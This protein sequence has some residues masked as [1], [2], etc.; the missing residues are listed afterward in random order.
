MNAKTVV[1][2][3]LLL[4]IRNNLLCQSTAVEN[5]RLWYN[6]P[7]R[8]STADLKN[9]KE[10]DPE[11]IKALPVGNGFLGAM[12]FGD[13]NREIIQLNEKSLWSG[14]PDD[15]NNP[16]AAGSLN[17]IRQLL[18]EK[19][20]KEANE[21]TEKTQV[22]KGVGSGRGSGANSPYGSFQILGNL[23]LDF[24]K[25]T[26]YSNYVRD[27]DLC[28]GVMKISYKQDG[29][30]YQ[31]EIFISYPN[32]VF[33]MHLT[34]SKKGALSFKTSL[35]RPELFTTVNEKNVLLMYGTL[36]NGKGGEGMQYAARLKAITL[37]GT[38]T[39]SD[40][41][42]TIR[43]ANEVI[44]L[45]TA[46]TNY[47]QEYPTYIG[48]DPKL[49]TIDQLKKAASMS[50][51]VLLKNH[52]DDYSAL[53]GKV[54]LS[55]SVN[56]TDTIP[57][58]I[59][60]KN[61]G[62]NTDDL[63]LQEIYF[64]YGRYLLISSS[65]EGSLPANLQGIWS[66]KI[67]TPWNGDYHTN[68][69]LQMNYW[70]ADVTNLQECFGPVTNLIESLVKPGEVTASVQY[71]AKGWCSEAIT[72]VWGYTAPG[73]GTSWGMYVA[74]G[75]W[76]CHHIWDHY[77][78]TLDRKYLER[79]Y[80][81]ML[82][83]AQFYLDWLVK[84]P[85]TGK[86]VSGPSTSPEN[87]F[88][89]PDGSLGSVCMGPSHDQ[90]VLHELFTNVLEASRILSDDNT[91]LIKITNALSDLATPQISSDGRIMEWNE[92]FKET[93]ITHRHVSHLYMLYPGNQIDPITNPELAKA[94]RKSLE[95]RTDVGTGWS[96][97]WKVNLW[98]RL[99]DGDR[100]YQL[101]KNLLRPT[102]TSSLNMSNGG[103]TYPNLFCAHPP[104][105]IDGNFGGTAGIAE[106]LLQS[107]NGCIELLPAL[108]KVWK[109]GEVKGLVARGGFVV[110]IKW[111]NSIPQKVVIKA[112]VKNKCIVRSAF[113]LKVDGLTE[114]SMK[115]GGSYVL[116]FN[117]EQGNVYELSPIK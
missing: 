65:R 86:L 68:I 69:N 105:Q 61:Q 67:Q 27:L 102:E 114:K 31:R 97:A 6:E 60:L 1:L 37:G 95:V 34:A 55:L 7:A 113:A 32:R 23:L 106:M 88:V 4:I 13:V 64:Q 42:V 117:A 75:G 109:E 84:D 2:L 16:E 57:T 62:S 41:L 5:V 116:E 92:E 3:F 9:G 26:K 73:E 72:N 104:F 52:V 35:T 18:F 89:A 12:V 82:K 54:S 44:L 70:P 40:S 76:L 36:K 77:M 103:G 80:P 24:G 78:F 63:H 19:K 91:L 20:Y 21:L 83:A 38:V 39:Y 56:G 53:F 59:R 46:A 17:K 99:K 66:D 43:G 100:A 112:N 58:D 29:I 25:E 10:N 90:E 111:K 47:K 107:Q 49:K 81:V 115:Q 71:H 74:G 50:Y 22:C 85:A 8:S 14:S 51:A 15:N 98:A 33:V 93:D 48:E 101:L 45:L 79:V 30:S 11:W 87:Q 110:D 94:A 108:P 96:L 28:R